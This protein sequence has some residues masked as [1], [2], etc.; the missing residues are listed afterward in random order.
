MFTHM[1]GCA[2]TFTHACRHTHTYEP[3]Y[4]DSNPQVHVHYVHVHVR[5]TF[6]ARGHTCTHTCSH[7]SCQ[8]PDP[9]LPKG[10][11]SRPPAPARPSCHPWQRPAHQKNRLPQPQASG[12]P[13]HCWKRGDRAAKT[14]E[15]TTVFMKWVTES[16]RAMF[17][18]QVQFLSGPASDR[19]LCQPQAGGGSAEGALWPEEPQQWA[20]GREAASETAMKLCSLFWALDRNGS[21]RPHTACPHP[22]RGSGQG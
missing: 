20:G 9:S 16:H 10:S 6:A 4:R 11:R 2:H 12:M 19:R 18:S 7:T 5:R 15:G 21:K 22:V 14:P 8:L 17:L 13:Q 1:H 3:V